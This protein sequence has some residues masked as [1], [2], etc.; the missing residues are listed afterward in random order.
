ML[1]EKL[2][3]EK[4]YILFTLLY[5]CLYL[6]IHITSRCK[7]ALE[8]RLDR[9]AFQDV[10]IP[11]LGIIFLSNC[12]IKIWFNSLLRQES[13]NIF[14][15]GSSSRNVFLHKP[16]SPCHSPSTAVVTYLQA[17]VDEVVMNGWTHSNKTLF[18]E[19]GS[20]LALSHDW[21]TVADLCYTI[22]CQK[23]SVI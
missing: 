3:G 20:S 14:Y 5:M 10:F 23:S 7:N 9:S 13:A 2:S 18:T 11:G 22:V 21:S 16:H 17:T 12:I 4:S 8:K 19:P 6:C 1:S 15:K